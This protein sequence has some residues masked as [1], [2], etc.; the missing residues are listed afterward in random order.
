MAVDEIP[1][2][3][4]GLLSPPRMEDTT[5]VQEDPGSLLDMDQA[6]H[7]TAMEEVGVL[8]GRHDREEA[9]DGRRLPVRT[10]RGRRPAGGQG[11]L[12]QG[13]ESSRGLAPGPP[14]PV[15]RHGQAAVAGGGRRGSFQVRAPQPDHGLDQKGP[16]NGQAMRVVPARACG[17]EAQGEN[18]PPMGVDPPCGP[19]HAPFGL[20]AQVPEPV[21]GRSPFT[22]LGDGTEIALEALDA[23]VEGREVH[24]GMGPRVHGT[25]QTR[26]GVQVDFGQQGPLGGL[27]HPHCQFR[28]GLAPGRRTAR[29]RAAPAPPRAGS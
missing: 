23:P 26:L 20:Q 27:L 6:G 12:H 10:P 8:Q 1:V 22:R 3:G 25:H 2:Q 16:F 21:K 14:G 19:Q 4:H 15:A 18:G 24:V 28:H 29:R 7:A 11:H 13:G 5:L 17:K 9:L